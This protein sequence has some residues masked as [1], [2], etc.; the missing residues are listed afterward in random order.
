[1]LLVVTG[2]V[3]A[4]PTGRRAGRWQ[5]KGQL[6]TASLLLGVLA[7]VALFP[8]LFTDA[9]P[10]E[11][12]LSR[13]LGTPSAE[14]LFGFDLQGCDYLAKTVY[15]A[16]TSLGITVAVVLGT[17]LIALVLGSLAGYVGGRTDTVLTRLTDVWSGIPLLLGGLLVLSGTDDRGPLQVSL[18]LVLFGWPAMVRVLR[19]SVL[20]ARQQDFV[21]AAR[22][23]G[24]G[25]G[26]LLLVHVLPHSL[27]P[28][29]VSA[30]AYAGFIV[31]AE[32]TLTF[33]GVGLRRPTESW[34]IQ[35]FEAQARVAVAPHLLVFPAV[36]LVTAV[37]GFV[38]L[39]EGLRRAPS[40]GG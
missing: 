24:A 6:I 40:D 4:A 15:G 22:A 12:S 26:R 7:V 19:A 3:L 33:A 29:I 2:T 10:R 21:T 32:A 38:L 27:R 1:M 18:V 30:S 13:S 25:P 14:H 5:G 39:G 8:G 9:D 17:T 11:C 28:L 23:L 36:F 20:E 34:G 37:V 31:A 16:R 35:L